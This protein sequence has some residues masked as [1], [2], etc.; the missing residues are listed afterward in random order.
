MNFQILDLMNTQGDIRFTIDP[1]VHEV[2]LCL[3]TRR[4][5]DIYVSTLEL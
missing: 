2:F 3:L 4:L 5:H 1:I